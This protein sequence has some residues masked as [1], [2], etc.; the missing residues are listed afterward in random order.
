MKKLLFSAFIATSL[1]ACKSETKAPFDLAN[2]KKEIEAA[3]QEVSNFM[4]KGD[5]VGL[6]S[7]YGTDGALLLNNMPAVKGQAN[8]VKAWGGFINSGIGAI[9]LNTTEVWGDEN[10]ITEDG[11]YVL[12]AKDGTQLDKGKYLV[13]WKKENGKWKFHRDISNSDLPVADNK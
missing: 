5:S 10:F 1:F 4:A 6:A 8:L 7:C 11:T 2:A 12:K 3:N 13:L 9:E